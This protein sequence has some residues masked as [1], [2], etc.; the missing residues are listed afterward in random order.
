MSGGG[1]GRAYLAENRIATSISTGEVDEVYLGA[2]MLTFKGKRGRQ[3]PEP[4]VITILF[5]Y[6][7]TNTFAM[8]L[9]GIRLDGYQPAGARAKDS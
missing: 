3:S 1:R 4:S 8:G 7:I 5:R 9:G 2:G 6:A